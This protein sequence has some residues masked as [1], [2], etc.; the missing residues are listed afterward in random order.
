MLPPYECRTLHDVLQ[1]ALGDIDNLANEIENKQRN[2]R[3]LNN[4]YLAKFLV[5]FIT[6]NYEVS[7][8]TWY[9]IGYSKI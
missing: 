9:K 2:E 7:K 8:I 3:Y 6:L 1:S 5:H 4:Q